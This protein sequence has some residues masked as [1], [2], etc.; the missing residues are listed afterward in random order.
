MTTV[1][2]DFLSDYYTWE[3]CPRTWAQMEFAWEDAGIRTF[4]LSA[5]EPLLLSEAI[6]KDSTKINKETLHATDQK[7]NWNIFKHIAETFQFADESNAYKSYV[8]LFDETLGVSDALKNVRGKFF[9]EHIGIAEHIPEKLYSKK[10]SESIAVLECFAKT[11]SFHLL[12][13][14]SIALAVKYGA[15]LHKPIFESVAVADEVAK[16][17]RLHKVEQVALAEA[18]SR[19][20][21]SRPTFQEAIGVAEQVFKNVETLKKENVALYDTVIEA[22]R[23]VM[24]NIA[25][26]EGGMSLLEF[27]EATQSAPGYTPFIDFKVGEYEYKEALVRLVVEAVVEQTEPSVSGV[28]MHVDIPD[29]QDR[30]TAEI[31][32]TD[33]PA[34][35]FFNKFFYKPPEVAV[36][37]RGGNTGDGIVTPNIAST[38]KKDENGNRYFE[39]ELLNASGQRV[40]GLITWQAVGY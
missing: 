20:F 25:I 5:D 34:K 33:A 14:E 2:V 4:G 27:E 12:A 8:R 28:I 26:T 9:A 29:T 21:Y 36:N 19:I 15:Y 37:L 3:S 22:C 24:S 17:L 16:D 39:V 18:A 30:G 40:T 1:N 13:A 32:T 23:A 11:V 38:D 7:Y 10:T 6:K 35:I 31:E